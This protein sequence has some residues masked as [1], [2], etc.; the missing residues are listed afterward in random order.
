MTTPAAGPA[1]LQLPL[2]SG[3]TTEAVENAAD[4][5]KAEMARCAALVVLVGHGGEDDERPRPLVI[6]LGGSKAKR[7]RRQIRA[8]SACK[9]AALLAIRLQ[10]LGIRARSVDG[11]GVRRR[12]GLSSRMLD[13]L[14]ALLGRRVIPVV[15]VAEP[16][17]ITVFRNALSPSPWRPAGQ[18]NGERVIRAVERTMGSDA[19][20][21]HELDNAPRNP[22]TVDRPSGG[23]VASEPTGTVPESRGKLQGT[24]PMSA[25][26]SA[27]PP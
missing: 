27:T 8:A 2:L 21:G 26:S 1:V 17:S 10:T 6:R 25:S 24:S 11:T 14:Q 9:M 16:L 19:Q 5:V 23:R 12:S 4:R 15:A 7:E 18:P 22:E 20:Y 3:G 13:R